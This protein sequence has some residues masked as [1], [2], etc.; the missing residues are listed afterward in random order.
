[1]VEVCS[2]G[3][4]QLISSWSEMEILRRYFCAL[5]GFIRVIAILLSCKTH[6]PRILHVRAKKEARRAGVQQQ[7][8]SD[9]WALLA[10]LYGLVYPI[11]S[12]FPDLW[13]TVYGESLGIG[14]LS[15]ISIG[16]GYVIG[17]QLGATFLD[18]V[19]H[20]VANGRDGDDGTN[21]YAPLHVYALLKGQN[22]NTGLPKYRL[23]LMI[24][25]SVLCP[26]GF[27]PYGK[28]WILSSIGVA[29]VSISFFIF[30]L[31][32]SIQLYIVDSYP[33]Y[34]AS[35]LAS[36]GMLRNCWPSSRSP[37]SCR[38]CMPAWGTAGG[39][40]FWIHGYCHWS[41]GAI[42]AVE[43]DASMRKRS[44]FAG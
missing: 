8:C 37:C 10:F 19:C 41:P 18:K 33:K 13:T 4:E 42:A 31:F 24:P 17:S 39:I 6:L 25:C 34:T 3:H 32:I 23:T 7:V 9:T 2:C 40:G 11:L 5:G 30:M 22:Q 27:F 16:I 35:S 38:V 28:R 29:F 20:S 12:T 21:P 44:K 26:V 15:Y 14:S 1:M 36:T 43:V